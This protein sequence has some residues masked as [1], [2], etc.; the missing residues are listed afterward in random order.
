MVKTNIPPI[1]IDDGKK[2]YDMYDLKT[3]QV[4][5]M[6]KGKSP[7]Q[8]AKK[9]ATKGVTDI[10]LRPKNSSRPELAGVLFRY[11][12]SRSECQRPMP[13]PKWL[14]DKLKVPAD[15]NKKGN[16]TK[17]PF[18]CFISIAKRTEYYKV[19]KIKGEPNLEVI[20]DFVKAL[21]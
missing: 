15:Q 9:A 19:P 7:L 18:K 10:V 3:G 4:V 11:K 17:Y 6:F 14:A 2:I 1:E 5:G 21:K 20:E 12:G 13:Y 8:A 16:E